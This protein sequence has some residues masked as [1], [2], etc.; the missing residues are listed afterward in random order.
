MI[1]FF[2]TSALLKR[3]LKEAGTEKVEALFESAT[4]VIVSSTTEVECASAFQRLLKTKYIDVEKYEHLKENIAID[5]PFFHHVEFDQAVRKDCCT[6]IDKYSLKPLD[7]IQLA[8][9]L[10]V[11]KEIDSFVV[12]DKQLKR[13]A[14][15]EGFTVIDPI[16]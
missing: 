7:T 14:S 10:Q 5:F 4:L 11:L 1:L 13:Y 2:D 12:S 16:Q 15:K 8:S 6:L 3:Y 9:A